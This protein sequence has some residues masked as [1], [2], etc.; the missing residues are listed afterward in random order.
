[1]E[2]HHVCYAYVSSISMML[3]GDRQPH[4]QANHIHYKDHTE[5]QRI[6]KYCVLTVII[7][8]VAASEASNIHP[9]VDVKTSCTK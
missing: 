7:H 5:Y 6:R 4:L 8:S 2:R 9:Q 1:M 3:I